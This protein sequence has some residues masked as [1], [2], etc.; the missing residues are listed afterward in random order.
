MQKEN[1]KIVKKIIIA[2]S[3]SSALLLSSSSVYAFD[4]GSI[5][6]GFKD[7]FSVKAGSKSIDDSAGYDIE[8]FQTPNK[9]Q[10]DYPWGPPVTKDKEILNRSLYMCRNNYAIQYDPKLQIALWTEEVL[11]KDNLMLGI[12]GQ[13]EYYK[14]DPEIPP[15]M[16]AT[17]ADY[18]ASGYGKVSLAPA[19]DMPKIQGDLDENQLKAFNKKSLDEAFYMTN[20]APMRKSLLAPN[21]LWTQLEN[22]TRAWAIQKNQVYV[23]TG[24][25]YLG[26]QTKGFIGTGQNKLAIPTHYFKIVTQPLTYG[27]IAYIIP[28]K[29]I[30]TDSFSPQSADAYYCG[31]AGAKRACALEDFI[32]PIK[33]IERLTGFE[34]YSKLAPGYAVRVKQDINELFKKK[35]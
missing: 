6:Q 24:P 32:V 29:D 4:F 26:G 21:G 1:R 11:K 25:L 2:S 31:G 12:T 30:A 8:Q 3:V 20:Q 9:C 15:K 33:E 10:V 18:D 16:Q 22:Q 17:A 34:T 13:T 27:S 19:F 28:N 14:P 23:I 5:M 35:Q 7:F